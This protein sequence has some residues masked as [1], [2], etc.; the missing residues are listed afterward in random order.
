MDPSTSGQV[1]SSQ[2]ELIGE[3]VDSV[4]PQAIKDVVDGNLPSMED[5]MAIPDAQLWSDSQ[6]ARNIEVPAALRP[7][8]DAELMPPPSAIPPRRR[9]SNEIRMKR[10]IKSWNSRSFC[11]VEDEKCY[12]ILNN[13]IPLLCSVTV[14]NDIAVHN[15]NIEDRKMVNDITR[16]ML[17]NTELCGMILYVNEDCEKQTMFLKIDNKT[18][19]FNAEGNAIAK[20]STKVFQGK[21]SVRFLGVFKKNNEIKPMLRLHQMQIFENNVNENEPCVFN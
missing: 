7:L 20:P 1:T 4:L 12:K 16:R 14:Y 3:N 8:S 9:V 2:L 21:V 5:L 18:K 17:E 19:F 15:V 6:F 13:G 10:K 11:F